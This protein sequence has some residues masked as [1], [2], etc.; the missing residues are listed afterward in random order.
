MSVTFQKFIQ[1]QQ[2]F[3]IRTKQ[4]HGNFRNI[5]LV[6]AL[7]DVHK[8][9]EYIRNKISYHRKTKRNMV[10]TTYQKCE[11][12]KGVQ[13]NKQKKTN[14]QDFK[15]KLKHLPQDPSRSCWGEGLY[16]FLYLEH[17]V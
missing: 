17:R 1:E 4:N 9:T 3:L 5:Y 11:G 13:T 2:F 14:T 10:I 15:I 6:N 12:E 8:D 16:A 7:L